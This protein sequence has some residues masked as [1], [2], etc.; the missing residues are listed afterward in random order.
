MADHTFAIV[1]PQP[2]LYHMVENLLGL[3]P[4]YQHF[5]K[6]KN[7]TCLV[8]PQNTNREFGHSTKAL[9][10]AIFPGMLVIDKDVFMNL[11]Q[12]TALHFEWVVASDRSAT[13]H[14]GVNQMIA[15]IFNHTKTHMTSFVSRAFRNLGII[16][17]TSIGKL[18]PVRISLVD[19]RSSE[20]RRLEHSLA[21]DL[22]WI[23]S[24]NSQ[25][26]L[27]VL[28]FE[29][30]SLKEQVQEAAL[31]NVLVGVHGNGLT[32]ALFITS[33]GAVV[34][35]IPG[36]GQRMIAFQQFAELR[37][38]TYFG[39]DSGD[40]TVVYRDGSCNQS[41]GTNGKLQPGCKIDGAKMNS[42]IK[43]TDVEHLVCV[44]YEALFSTGR[45]GF[46]LD[47]TC[48]SP[49]RKEALSLG[50]NGKC[51]LWHGK[52]YLCRDL[53]PYTVDSRDTAAPHESCLSGRE[54]WGR[55]DRGQF[56]CEAHLTS[57]GILGSLADK[58]F[59]ESSLVEK[60]SFNVPRAPLARH[61]ADLADPSDCC[62]HHKLCIIAP[63]RDSC[64]SLSRQI[65]GQ[66]TNH[67]ILFKKHMQEFLTAV[68]HED[69]DLIIVNQ[70]NRGLFNK[71]ALF[72][73]GVDIAWSRGCDYISM[74]DVVSLA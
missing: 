53:S 33:P 61:G 47:D 40:S 28:L 58:Y 24:G 44:V 67:L 63:F 68:G 26:E 29:Q 48:W 7:P 11:I 73:V 4:T 36:K 14:G 60:A 71:G 2:H 66:R 16:P 64:Q 74:H 59:K 70:S 57:D 51:K 8:L 1:V 13:D 20:N 32:H 34:E 3:W 65:I 62:E 49:C 31:T 5:A 72:N 41:L 52:E 46:T 54:S 22:L 39:I 9:V 19:R 50:E 10:E 38:N 30:L 6:E 17:R 23:L 12:R 35:I 18:Y 21:K 43:K 42:I 56:L 25:V 69:Y 55:C 27:R 15:G 45:L 37:G